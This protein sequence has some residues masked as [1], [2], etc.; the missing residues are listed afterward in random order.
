MKREQAS[1]LMLIVPRNTCGVAGRILPSED[2]GRRYLLRHFA[3]CKR[4]ASSYLNDQSESKL[5]S[6]G[7][8]TLVSANRKEG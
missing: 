6:T 3:T 2:C 4:L 7:S 5:N 8:R 1:K